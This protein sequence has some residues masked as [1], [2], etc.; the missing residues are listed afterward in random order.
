MR[1]WDA[2][3]GGTYEEAVRTGLGG[4]GESDLFEALAG[5]PTGAGTEYAFLV[6]LESFSLRPVIPEPGTLSLLLLAAPVLWFANRQR[7][8]PGPAG[9]TSRPKPQR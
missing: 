9:D 6:G 2:S 1:A 8:K 7:I 4:Y 5:A 3:L